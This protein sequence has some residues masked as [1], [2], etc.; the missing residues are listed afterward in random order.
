[1]HQDDIG[2]KAIAA[3][4]AVLL[5]YSPIDPDRPILPEPT[6]A[7]LDAMAASYAA[8]RGLSLEEQ[9]IAEWEALEAGRR[10]EDFDRI[11]A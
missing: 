9:L 6:A 7:E 1:M 5:G 10:L 3:A 8:E 2:R 4:T 11:A